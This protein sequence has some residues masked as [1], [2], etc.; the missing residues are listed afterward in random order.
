MKVKYHYDDI[1]I[2]SRLDSIQAA[3]LRVKLKYLDK[4]NAFR[5]AVADYYDKAFIVHPGITIPC[6]ADYS[7]HI[8]HQYTIMINNGSRD[9]LKKFLEERKIPSMIYYPGPLHM[10]AAYRFLGYKETDFPVTTELCRKVL[11]LPM[12]P[13]ME[14]DQLEY[15]TGNVLKF[16]D[17]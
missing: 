6:R 4:Y 8:F 17:Q 3:I 12:H 9:E 1:G 16:F 7:S 13:D 10:Q 15:I 5:R 11:S 14:Q 2:N